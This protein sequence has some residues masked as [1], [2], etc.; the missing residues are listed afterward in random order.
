MRSK[1]G[2]AHWPGS[3]LIQGKGIEKEVIPKLP[4]IG[5]RNIFSASITRLRVKLRKKVCCETRNDRVAAGR[6]ED[7]I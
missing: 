5:K 3:L 1:L 4:P 7:A 6:Q 2:E